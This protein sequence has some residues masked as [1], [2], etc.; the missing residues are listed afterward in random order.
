[1]KSLKISGICAVTL[2]SLVLLSRMAVASDEVRIR[3]TQPVLEV[4]GQVNNF[5]TTPATSQQFGYVSS[6]DGLNSIFSAAAPQ[7]ETTAQLTFFTQATNVSVRSNGP[8]RII[9]RT[10]TTIIYLNS[11]PASFA[12]PDSFR[13][14]TAVQVSTMTQQVIVNT[15]T[16]SFSVD[17]VNTVTEV[18]TFNINGGD[19]RI[20]HEG[21]QFRTVLSGQLNNGTVAGGP[22]GW[23]SGYAVGI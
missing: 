22:T 11:A 2:L 19:V 8:L 9:N 12:N 3:A 13:S 7:N 15:V 1:M 4:I 5:S 21:D 10:G 14:G 23:F 18:S 20:G 17:N 6:V 16:G